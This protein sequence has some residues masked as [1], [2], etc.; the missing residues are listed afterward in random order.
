MKSTPACMLAGLA[1]SVA[2]LASAQSANMTLPPQT[3]AGDAF[4]IQTTGSGAATLYIVGPGQALR[5][6]LQLGDAASFPAGVLYSA[7]HYA[8]I[9]VEGT[10]TESKE[11]DIAPAPKPDTLSFLA[12]PSRLPVGLHSGI[13][14]SAYVF[15]AYNNLITTPMPVSFEL[16]NAAGISENRTVT[17]RNGMAWT[18]MDSATKQGTAKLI[19]RVADVTSTRV[20]QEV[21]GDPCKITISARPDAG[22]L[23]VETAPIHDCSGNPVPD[24]TIVTFTETYDGAQ[25]TVD[26]PIKQGFARVDLPAYAGAKISVAS[27]VVAGNEIR[28]GGGR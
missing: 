26:V 4:T 7:G 21:P 17:T 1:L 27:G 20:I 22:K 2:P 10:T 15:D 11:F 14:G 5:K 8:A 18:Q 3:I 25:S 28:W 6:A 13:S 12:K 19:A 24:G 9:L 23:N 16:S